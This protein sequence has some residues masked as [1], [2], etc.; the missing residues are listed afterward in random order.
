MHSLD[1]IW[2]EC[3]SVSSCS[4]LGVSSLL[5]R[6]HCTVWSM[7]SELFWTER[8]GKENYQI[9]SQAHRN[10]FILWRLFLIDLLCGKVTKSSMAREMLEYYA[11]PAESIGVIYVEFWSSISSPA[12]LL[13][14][15]P[16]VSP[17]SFILFWQGWTGSVSVG[18]GSKMRFLHKGK[19]I[20]WRDSQGW[21]VWWLSFPPGLT[22]FRA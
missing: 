17:H 12:P 10:F 7:S 3:A 8:G 14:M 22:R 20:K 13:F 19:L 5:W 15:Y 11:L 4:H 6:A 1:Q 16:L 21:T 9:T 2:G 18:Q